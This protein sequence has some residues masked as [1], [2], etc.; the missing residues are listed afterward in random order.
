VSVVANVAVNL[1][2]RNATQ[3]AARFKKEMDGAANAIKRTDRAAATATANVQRFG[4]AFRSVLGPVVAVFGAVQLLNKSLNTFADRQADTAI[5]TK[6][7]QR[8]GKTA[9]DIEALQKAADRLGKQTLFNEDDFRQGFALLTSFRNIGVDSYTRVANAA[10]DIAATT[11]QDVNSSFLQLAK[12]L[13]DPVKGMTALSRSGTTFTDQQKDLVKELVESNRALEAQNFILTEVEKQY[14]GN[15][16]AAGSAG[17]AGAVDSLGEAMADL[18]EVI[19]RTFAP[20]LQNILQDITAMVNSFVQGLQ[21]ME[22]AYA[23]FLINLRGKTQ[24]ELQ[25]QIARANE[26]VVYNQD[27][28]SK[29]DE[30]TKGGRQTA[31]QLRKKIDEARKV[32]ASLQKDLDR[33]LG[34]EAP[35]APINAT[36]APSAL[37]GTTG[38]RTKKQKD[39]AQKLAEELAKSLATGEKLFTQFS[40]QAV[41]TGE[42]SEIE[43]KRLQIQYDYQDRAEQIAELK[44]AEQRINL[45]IINDEIKRLETRQLDLEIL[46]EQLEIFEKIAGLDFSKLEGLGEKAFG[47][48]DMP[49]GFAADLPQLAGNKNAAGKIADGLAPEIKKLQDDLNPIKLAT[50]TIT[51]GAFAIG[52]AF[53]T[54]FGDVITGAKSTQEALADAFQAIG[55]AFISMA[56]EIIAKQMT[57]IILQTIFNA[58]SGMSSGTGIKGTEGLGE[59]AFSGPGIGSQGFT[60]GLQLFADGGF[61]TG[62]TNALIAEGGEPEYVIPA[63]KMRG[64]MNRYAAGARG[65][66][67]IPGSGEQAGGEMGGG[68]AVAAPIDV[69]YTVERINSVDYVTADQFRSGMQ[70]AAEQGARRGEQRTLAN[71][72]QNTTTRRK[73]GL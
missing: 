15:A 1:D 64:A 68:T 57:L 36:G 67:V 25:A 62:P 35:I 26:I 72:R 16:A 8:L 31:E 2:A 37:P 63:S 10:A 53:S 65:S 38:G 54:A 52:D 9:S 12:A 40:R 34:L 66:S 73:L 24:A 13:E 45:S 17:Y 18:S 59:K 4:I 55:K 21:N 51:Q 33:M 60:P 20:V 41:L 29:A 7:L 70:Q 6:G 19:G 11:K 32:R 49:D 69:R 3:N 14:Q 56:L 43:R 61:V 30:T 22:R 50:E 44:N 23:N 46:R 39:E 47:K 28:L 5:L 58:L 42:V 71:I 48:R 27:Q